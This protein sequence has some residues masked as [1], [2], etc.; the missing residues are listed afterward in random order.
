[1]KQNYFYI[2]NYLT[3]KNSN[4][5]YANHLLPN[6]HAFN[7]KTDILHIDRKRRKLNLLEALEINIMQI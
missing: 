4:Y 2:S 5:T 3:Q 6:N 7:S 1:M